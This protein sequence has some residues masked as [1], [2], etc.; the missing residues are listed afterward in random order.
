MRLKTE[1]YQP[2]A[3]LCTLSTCTFLINDYHGNSKC[4]PLTISV[5][6]MSSVSMELIDPLFQPPKTCGT[7]PPKVEMPWKWRPCF[8][9]GKCCRSAWGRREGQSIKYRHVACLA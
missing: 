3:F 1:A 9:R 8:R 2:G 6:H 7:S 5:L 4:F